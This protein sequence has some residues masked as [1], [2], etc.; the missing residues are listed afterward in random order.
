MFTELEEIKLNVLNL[1]YFYLKD[2]RKGGD[3]NQL[4]AVVFQLRGR[5]ILKSLAVEIYYK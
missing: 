1:F 4:D 3:F 5:L 2:Q